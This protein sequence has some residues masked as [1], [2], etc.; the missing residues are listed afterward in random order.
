[1]RVIALLT[2]AGAA[3]AAVSRASDIARRGPGN[4][5]MRP[6]FDALRVPS[7]DSLSTPGNVRASRASI[8]LHAA[9]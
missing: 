7:A 5:A 6:F 4:H 9:P 8:A 1:M 3:G 2:V